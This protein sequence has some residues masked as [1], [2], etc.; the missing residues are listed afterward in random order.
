MKSIFSLQAT[1]SMAVS[2]TA[3][4][5]SFNVAAQ[6]KAAQNEKF[7]AGPAAIHII[8]EGK[9]TDL[10]QE[11]RFLSPKLNRLKLQY[12]DG[13]EDRKEGKIVYIFQQDDYLRNKKISN[14]FLETYNRQVE[15][16]AA[17]NGKN[18]KTRSASTTRPEEQASAPEA[19]LTMNI[20]Q[21]LCLPPR[22]CGDGRIRPW[23][24]G[25]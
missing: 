1:L 10:K 14:L 3:V 12:I 17:Q 7:P 16:S 15:Q 23:P 19:N 8:L 25:C 11:C 21:L 9:E 18:G 20:K 22:N 24:C 2:I 4:A 5:A 6:N 13:C